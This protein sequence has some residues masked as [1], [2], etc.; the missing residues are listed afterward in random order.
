M[1]TIPV[2]LHHKA[3]QSQHTRKLFEPSARII[4]P[5][6]CTANYMPEYSL[7]F[8]SFSLQESPM[9]QS[10]RTNWHRN[11]YRFHQA[12]ELGSKEAPT[13]S[14]GDHRDDAILTSSSVT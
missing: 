12:F 11:H 2:S 10:R 6:F 1:A 3:I 7:S 9:N 13:Q 8:T 5:R 14:P 4:A